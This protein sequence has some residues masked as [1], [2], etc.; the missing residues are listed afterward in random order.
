MTVCIP[1]F[2]ASTF[3]AFF[4]FFFFFFL[5]VNSN[6]TWVHCSRTVYHCSCTVHVLK[7]IKN[8]SHDT[9]YTFKNYFATVF[10]VFS[11]NKFNP[12]GPPEVT[13]LLGSSW[14]ATCFS[15]SINTVMSLFGMKNCILNIAKFVA[16]NVPNVN[17]HNNQ[18]PMPSVNLPSFF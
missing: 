14:S 13:I 8:E 12:N 4:F 6:L 9:I 10:S 16:A 2:A 3:S 17:V 7:N 11:N 5:R 1:R 15:Q 18:N